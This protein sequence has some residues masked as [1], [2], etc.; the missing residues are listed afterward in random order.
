MRNKKKKN[1]AG[2][3]YRRIVVIIL[4]ARLNSPFLVQP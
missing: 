4:A 1:K 3:R 2:I